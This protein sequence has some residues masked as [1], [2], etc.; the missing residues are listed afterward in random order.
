V[1]DLSREFEIGLKVGRG[2][3]VFAQ[4]VLKDA[5]GKDL[6]VLL[7]TEECYDIIPELELVASLAYLRGKDIEL[8]PP[9]K[10]RIAACLMRSARKILVS[11]IELLL[12]RKSGGE[13]GEG[14]EER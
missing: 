11:D 5:L 4:K 10:A 7:Y 14:K 13:R 3:L 9:L 1:V 2:S 8:T 12:E 6:A